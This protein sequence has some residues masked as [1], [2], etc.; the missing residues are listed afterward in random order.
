MTTTRDFHARLCIAADHPALAGHFPERPVVPGVVLLDRV[1]AALER[2]RGVR[3]AGFPQVKFA[4]PLL[5]EQ[6]AELVLEDAGANAFRFRVS[7]S[8]ATIASGTIE[9]A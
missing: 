1:A 6:E 7:R 2:W 4:L 8:T 9:A 3:V 5:P